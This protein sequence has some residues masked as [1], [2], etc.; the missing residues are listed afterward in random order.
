MRK[1]VWMTTAALVLASAMA[2]AQPQATEP[3][4]VTPTLGS[5]D[6]G[7]RIGSASGDE[8]R[9]E[10]YRDLRT[11]L[12][13]NLSL[14]KATDTYLLN[15]KA[16][17]IGYNDQAYDGLYRNGKLK[18]TFSWNSTPLNYSYESMTPYSG[19]VISGNTATYSLNPVVQNGVQTG[20]FAGLPANAAALATPSIYR[21]LANPFNLTQR[22]D[23]V[24]VGLAYA[25]T[26]AVDLDFGF[27]TTKKH[28]YQP[29]GASFAFVTGVELPLPIDQRTND[30]TAGLEWANAKGMFRIAYDGSYFTNDIQTLVWS[31]PSYGPNDTTN[32]SGYSNGQGASTGRMAL[33]PNSHMNV[34]SVTGLRKL[35]HHSTINGVFSI[36]DSKQNGE[37][38]PFT[39]NTFILDNPSL[40]PLELERAT[41]EAGA[42][43]YNAALNFTSRPNQYVGFTA[44]YRYNKHDNTTPT[45]NGEEYVRFDQVWEETGGETEQFDITHNTFNAD[46]SFTPIAF[47]TLRVGYGFDKTDHT[48]RAYADLKDNTLRASIDTV[49]NQYISLRGTYEHTTRK[50]EGFDEAAI[51]DGGAQPDLRFFDDASRKRDRGSIV[52]TL[53]P[54]SMVNVNVIYANGKDTYNDPAQ[55]FGLLD[56]SNSSY[57]VGLDLTPTAQV[58]FGVSYGQDEYK[59]LQESRNANPA[60]DPSWTDPNRNWSLNNKEKVKNASA[61]L[62]LMQVIV[63]TD[64]RFGFDFSDSNNAFVFGGPRIAALA[65]IGQ[66]LPLPAVTNQWQRATVD[67]KHMFTAKTGI[68]LAYWYEK[69]DVVDFATIDLPGEPGVPR[70]DYL[71]EINTGY[72]NRPYK[73]NTGFIRLLYLF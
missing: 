62:D 55:E 63:R 50:G 33:A 4:G 42:R 21:A 64:L 41:A 32:S 14:D 10:R 5:V 23:V 37:L 20:V 19:P 72:G 52:L 8:A 25:A 9:F 36:G 49:G 13:T 60:P 1:T 67:L 11:G 58:A 53:S 28:G 15:I 26:K 30:V 7:V 70:I 65:A 2:Q 24:N 34:V 27:S 45:F 38:I 29:Y 47:T 40:Y 35:A 17:N 44:K 73:G 59:A 69:F 68:A 16:E 3:V 18:A 51:V 61:Y 6:F 46:L 12:F 39:I 43:A 71:G 48:S 57:N 31:S 22:R 66:F 56:N 54:T